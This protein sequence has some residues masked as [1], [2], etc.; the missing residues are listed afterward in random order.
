MTML[1]H[2]ATQDRAHRRGGATAVALGDDRLSYA[3]LELQSNRF[4]QGLVELGCRSGERV[5]LFVPKSPLAVIAMLGSLKAG[6]VYVPIDLASPAPRLAKIVSAAD[7][8]GLSPR[9]APG[10][11]FPTLPPRS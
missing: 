7:P 10:S 8:S 4:A 5:C 3:E 2:E 1:L 6:C 11:P 9:F